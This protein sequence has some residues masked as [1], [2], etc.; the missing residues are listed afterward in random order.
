MKLEEQ[1]H[2]PVE[3][4]K[5][6]AQLTEGHVDIS[7]QVQ[8]RHGVQRKHNQEENEV[9]RELEHLLGS[10]GRAARRTSITMERTRLLLM[11]LA[12]GSIVGARMDGRIR[13]C[14]NMGSCTSRAYV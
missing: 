6:P 10:V 5:A 4:L 8:R 2:L 9:E 13:R 12:T 3:R 14:D 1:R 7:H 11:S